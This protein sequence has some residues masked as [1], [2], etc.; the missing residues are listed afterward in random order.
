M[1]SLTWMNDEI[2][3]LPQHDLRTCG[4]NSLLDQKADKRL[5]SVSYSSVIGAE[6]L[7]PSR[8]I[9]PLYILLTPAMTN[10]LVEHGTTCITVVHRSGTDPGAFTGGHGSY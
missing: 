1:V 7:P 10:I 6:A 4:N 3:S 5:N 9:L 2:P 8:Q